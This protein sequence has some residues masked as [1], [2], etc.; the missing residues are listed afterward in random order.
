MRSRRQTVLSLR[1]E[2]TRAFAIMLVLLVVGGAVTFG[3][4][5]L[6]V[7]Q[8][9]G[10]S[11]QL[12]R[13]VTVTAALRTELIADQSNVD[14]MVSGLQVNRVAAIHGQAD[15]SRTFVKALAIFPSSGASHALLRDA[16]AKWRALDVS[17]GLWGDEIRTFHSAGLGALNSPAT[18]AKL[19]SV[20]NANLAARA[21]IEA[22]Q[23]PSLAAMNRG[24]DGANTLQRT[25]GATLA[26][27]LLVAIGGMLY[28]RR[29]MARDL[30]RPVAI[31]HAGVSQLEAGQL[32]HRIEVVRPDELG[33]LAEAF[34]HMADALHDSHRTLTQRATHDLLTG[35]ANR[36]VLADRL[37]SS[38][39]EGNDR[40]ARHDSVLFI[41]VDDFKDVNDTLGHDAGDQLLIQLADRLEDC[42]RP[43]DL[44]ARLGGDEF[45]ILVAE[46]DGGRVATDIS[47]RVLAALQTPFA[48][49]GVEITVAVSIGVARRQPETIDAAELLRQADFAMYMAKGAGKGRFAAFDA[50]MHDDMLGRSA[51][52][53][54][55]TEVV[56]LHQLRLD[57][58]PVVDLNTGQVVGIEALVRWQHPT[59]GLLPPDEFIPLAEETGAIDAI[60]C[61]ALD[62]AARQAAQWRHS[63]A[64]Q[65]DLW[66]SVNLSA[67][68]LRLPRNLEAIQHVLA[69]PATEAHKVVLEVTET[70]LAVDIDDVVA[71]LQSLKQL[72]VRIAIDDFGTGYSSLSTLARLPVEILKIDR[73]FVSGPPSTA[74]SVPLL[75]TI[76]G[77]ASKLDLT[78]IA[79]GIEQ[80]DQLNLLR[81]LGCPWGQGF[82]LGRPLAAETLEPLLAQAKDTTLTANPTTCQPDYPPVTSRS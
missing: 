53:T 10:I 14:I 71:S 16:R 21:P 30:L 81:D 57:Y 19:E 49:G 6:I 42:V 43:S 47:E 37:T 38:F 4:V 65:R 26:A 80:P 72:G 60:G 70:A 79:E 67:L 12:A 46:D 78:V 28:F 74:G 62:T 75:E 63:M 9:G 52:K 41:D 68:Q 35:L 17:L 45:A 18:L 33:E 29:R 64:N 22:L 40:R 36:A 25:L 15:L 23:G 39:A 27:A 1:R 13:E 77:L 3:G 51:L 50:Q 44:V 69:D 73:A 56:S 7:G 24:L 58:Q 61:W 55:L 66:V 20:L 2:W 82:L 59:R 54:D 76:M 8:F 32:D 11:R 34:N 31:M 48:L 5:E